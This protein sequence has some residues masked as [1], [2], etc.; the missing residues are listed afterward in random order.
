MERKNTM[1]Q[2]KIGK[3]IADCRKKKKL[4]QEQLAE[5]I[6]VSRKSVSRWENGSTMPDYAL[7]DSLCKELG[8]TINELYYAKKMIK[9]DYK[10]LSENNLKMFMKEKYNKKVLFKKAIGFLIL[11]ILVFVITYLIMNK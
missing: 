6:G 3:F 1:N 11:G 5:V 10:E 2:E 4:T 7:L 9:E 8:I